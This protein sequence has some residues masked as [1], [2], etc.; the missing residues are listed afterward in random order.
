MY[1]WQGKY[2]VDEWGTPIF[3][4]VD[5][6]SWKI[7]DAEGNVL[8]RHSY[9]EDKVPDGVVVPDVVQRKTHKRKRITKSFDDSFDYVPRDMRKEWDT[10][11]LL[12]KVRVRENSPKN[13]RWIKIKVVDEKE[14][15]LIR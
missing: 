14:L 11:G 10:V 4:T 12:G 9:D 13:P 1:D 6:I 3:D 8:E 15:W 2:E 5:Q 7:V